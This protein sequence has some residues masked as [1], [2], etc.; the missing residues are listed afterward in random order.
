MLLGGR[1]FFFF[2]VASPGLSSPGLGHRDDLPDTFGQLSYP[3]LTS[4]RFHLLLPRIGDRHSGRHLGTLSGVGW[5]VVDLL[6][7]SQN[8][9]KS[10]IMHAT[11]C[12]VTR[13]RLPVGASPTRTSPHNLYKLWNRLALAATFRRRC[14]GWT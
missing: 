12:A 14:D 2:A 10:I 5:Q 8:S 4:S 6:Q 7:I 13:R 9:V 3:K 11:V 1:S